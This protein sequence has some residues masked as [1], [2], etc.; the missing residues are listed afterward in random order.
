MRGE[1]ATIVRI[2]S[3]VYNLTNNY[4]VTDNI[5]QLIVDFGIVDK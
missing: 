2:F 5:F 1:E 4:S 3:L